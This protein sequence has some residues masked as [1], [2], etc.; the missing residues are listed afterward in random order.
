MSATVEPSCQARSQQYSSFQVN[1]S[2]GQG[3][4]AATIRAEQGHYVTLVTDEPYTVR[5][6]HSSNMQRA[7]KGA[8]PMHKSTLL[9][10]MQDYTDYDTS[11]VRVNM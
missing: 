10:P 8:R 2:Y 9:I 5:S 6:R 1:Q 11:N 7:R 3:K 4:K